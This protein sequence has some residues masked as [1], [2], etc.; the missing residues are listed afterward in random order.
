MM[1]IVVWKT[2]G[3]DFYLF[4]LIL[5]DLY[6]FKNKQTEEGLGEILP[7]PANL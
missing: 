1:Y 6:L 5:N 3:E 2:L 7:F 4:L